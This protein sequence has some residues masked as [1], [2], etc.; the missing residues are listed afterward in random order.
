LLTIELKIQKYFNMNRNFELY[1]GIIIRLLFCGIL[2]ILSFLGQ[3]QVLLQLEIPHQVEAI[4][5]GENDRITFK[6]TDMPNEWQ[7][8]KIERIIAGDNIIIF[9]DGI[10]PLSDITHF[11]IYKGSAKAA[12]Q[13]F[14]GFGLGYFLFGGIAD[15]TGDYKFT[16][17]NFAI[18]SVSVGLGWLLNKIVSKRTFTIGKNGVLRIIDISFPEPTSASD[19]GTGKVIP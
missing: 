4:K 14:S 12:G 7:T 18:G 11:R 2:S 15:L 1:K 17:T 6:S 3:A 5:Y 13:L 10:M 8:R 16:W 9:T 19:G